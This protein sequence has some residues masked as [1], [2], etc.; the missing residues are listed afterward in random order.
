MNTEG[1]AIELPWLWA[2]LAAYAMATFVSIW[3]ATRQTVGSVA[4]V[5]NR[6]EKL[7]L[8]LLIAAVVLLTSAIVHRWVRIGHGPW[9]S[10]FELLM[11]QLWSLGLVFTLVYWRL[12]GLRPSS[13]VALPIL[14]ILGTWGLTLEPTASHF[15]ATYYNF[16]K[17]FHVGLG[18]LY[19][20]SLLIGVA[21]SGVMLLR[22][23]VPHAL[24]LRKG[25]ELQPR[26]DREP[27]NSL[28]DA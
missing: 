18:K 4:V 22:R 15:P 28:A 5:D 12:A 16:W 2:G 9:I 6:Y 13:I 26:I 19:L 20:A 25:A 3:G 17:W 14:W 11:S 10:L 7:V 21:L 1:F 27:V 23:F 24:L 8:A